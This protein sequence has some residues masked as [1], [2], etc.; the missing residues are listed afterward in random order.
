MVNFE[1][2]TVVIACA[3]ITGIVMFMFLG[4][5]RKEPVPLELRPQREGLGTEERRKRKRAEMEAMRARMAAKRA[6]LANDYQAR[7]AEQR[8]EKI[9]EKDVRSSQSVCYQL[10]SEQVLCN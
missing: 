8:M 4:E 10:D 7:L 5:G 2:S 1:G 3:S 9:T 6:N